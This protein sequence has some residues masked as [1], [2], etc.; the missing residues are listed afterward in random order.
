MLPALKMHRRRLRLMTTEKC[1]YF[2]SDS[3]RPFHG[4]VSTSPAFADDRQRHV[5]ADERAGR[6]RRD[7]RNPPARP[8]RSAPVRATVARSR[9]RRH[10]RWQAEADRDAAG[11]R[12]VP[13]GFGRRNSFEARRDDRRRHRVVGFEKAA[14]E[15][16]SDRLARRQIEQHR[17]RV[18][19]ERRT[20]VRAATSA[21]RLRH[22]ARR[23]PLLVVDVAEDR[24]HQLLV[25][26]RGCRG[27]D[28]RS[29]RPAASAVRGAV[30]SGIGA[31]SVVPPD[32]ASTRSSAKSGPSSSSMWRISTIG[33]S[34]RSARPASSRKS[35]DAPIGLAPLPFLNVKP[36]RAAPAELPRDVTIRHDR[37]LVHEP[38]RADVR[39]VRADRSRRC[40]RRPARRAAVDRLDACSR[41]RQTSL[42]LSLNCSCARAPDDREHRPAHA[43]HDIAKRLSERAPASRHDVP[44]RPEAPAPSA[45]ASP[46]GHESRRRAADQPRR[47]SRRGPS[48]MRRGLS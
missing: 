15:V 23:E 48:A 10:D 34:S 12:A 31:A 25:G 41:D 17:S 18:A 37:V 45:I 38:A 4:N 36:P 47:A 19:A 5:H 43:E 40:G 32:A 30:A 39:D 11:R 9:R 26:H 13:G 7:R 24:L 1:W 8:R 33:N 14:G 22:L 29:P 42:S 6:I 27:R 44:A 46:D 16:Q 3:W 21:S 20:V 35:I 2:S 28:S